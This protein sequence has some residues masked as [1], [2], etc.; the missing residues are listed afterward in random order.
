MGK[1]KRLDKWPAHQLTTSQKKKK[2]S[3]WSVVFPYSMQQ[4]FISP[5]DYNVKQKV[6]FI[7]QPTMTG[8]VPGLRSSKALLKAK[9]EPRKGHGHHL[10]VCCPSDPLQLSES[11]RNH[12]IWDVCSA[13]S[14]DASS[15]AT[16]AAG[17]GQQKGP[18]ITSNHMPHNQRFRSAMN[19]AR[20]FA[21]SIIFTGPLAKRY[22]FF[23]HL[24]NVLQGKCFHNQ[25]EAKML[26]KNSSNP[27]AWIFMLRE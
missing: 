25:Q 15:T 27:E 3:F 23:K 4:W 16:P 9:P 22:H 26:A 11:Q 5:S 8:S 24:N 1:V 7:Q 2:S 21:S 13:S 10:V 14:R 20:S 17:A 12:D 19:W 6:D 18:T